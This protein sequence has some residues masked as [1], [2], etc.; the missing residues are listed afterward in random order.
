MK[1]AVNT[2]LLLKNRLEGI[3]QFTYET[4]KRITQSHPEHSFYFIFDREY[5]SSFLFS[6]NITPVVAHPQ[7]RHP[8]LWYLFFEFGVPSK[9]KKIKPDIF[10]ST[11]GW[12]PT[13]IK[14]PALNVI[15]DLN[16]IHH[17]EFVPPVVD[18]YYRRFFHTFAEKATRIAT[19]SEFSKNDI[20][21]QFGIE[22][23]KIDVVYCG[24]NALYKPLT[25]EEQVAVKR[26][27]SDGCEFFLF[28]GL[29]H[30]RK[31]LA[32]IFRAFDSFKST[33]GSS[34]KLVVVGSKKWWS[35]EIED[36]YNALAHK[37]DVLMMGYQPTD[38]VVRLTA[39]SKAVVYPSFFEGF[40][41]PIVD[42]F[43]ANA[44]LITSNITSMP[45]IAG[46]AALLVDPNDHMSIAEAMANIDADERLRDE[47]KRRG[48]ERRGLFTWDRTA[49]LLWNSIEKLM[50]S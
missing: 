1:I 15:H 2:R 30:K 37:D 29:I 26:D 47:L 43:N 8:Y 48:A 42:A 31:N 24:S 7:A 39:A 34:T 35:G 19:V 9:L 21:R 10:V 36:T 14:V 45:E 38:V 5:D 20:S 32:N 12:M 23:E 11:D 44:P 50:Q 13:N 16:F 46:D 28:V 3:G 25:D 4:L 18:R 22:A 6:D 41:L 17:P 40:G 49:E 33:T 27:F